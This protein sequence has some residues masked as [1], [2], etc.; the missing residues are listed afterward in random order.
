[1]MREYYVTSSEDGSS[2]ILRVKNIIIDWNR[3]WLKQIVC[4]PFCISDT[5]FLYSFIVL[6][7]DIWKNHVIVMFIV[8]SQFGKVKMAP[9]VLVRTQ[10]YWKHWKNITHKCPSVNTTPESQTT[11][12]YIFQVFMHTICFNQQR[13]QSIIIFFTLKIF[14]LPS[15]LEVT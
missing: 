5:V 2:K 8:F 6:L 1:M 13:F 11:M 12:F 3:C 10:Q 9:L 4:S 14:E 7:I 15:S